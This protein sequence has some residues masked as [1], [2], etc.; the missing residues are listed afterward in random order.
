MARVSYEFIKEE[1]K[2]RVGVI[3]LNRPEKMNAWHSPMVQELG[4]SLAALDANDA[5]RAIVLT[6]TG[7]KAFS[8]GQDLAETQKFMGGEQGDEWIEGWKKIYSTIRNLTKPLIAALN[9]VA[10][11]SAFQIALLCDIRVG[12]AGSRMG[13]PEINSG[14]PSI[15][16]P[17]VIG[18]RVGVGKSAELC[19]TG[20]IMEAD[21]AHRIGL[22][23]YM[24]PQDKVM[25]KAM[26]V[27]EMLAAKPPVA[28]RLNKKRFAEVT[29]A[30]FDDAV[31]AGRKYQAQAFASGEP[32]AY[33][34]KFFEERAKRGA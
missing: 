4:K 8:A 5:V 20:R 16:G 25:A 18:D 12:H 14:I 22:I 23:H 26:E 1:I 30:S 9:G 13:Q 17:W 33:M 11:G 2:G 34:A 15:M 21:E 3:T 10:A 32:Q 19:L 28:M 6:G 27:A 31:A 29:Q 24:V 7:D